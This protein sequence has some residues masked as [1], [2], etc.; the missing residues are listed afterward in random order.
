MAVSKVSDL[1][2]LFNEIFEDTLFVAREQNMMTNLVT[3]YSARGWM[4]RNIANYPSLT[5]E[6]VAEAVD[7]Q[8][9]TTFDKSLLATLTPGEIMTQVV[10]TDRRIETD[11]ED[12]RADAS[13]EMGNAVATKI[14]TDIV[15]D[16]GSLT[17][18]GPGAGNSATIAKVAVCISILRNRN[19]P[20]P[21]YVV[22]H[23]YHWHDVWVELGQPDQYYALLGDVANQ[24]LRDF[25]VGRWLNVMWFVNS[26]IAV[27]SSDDATSA[28]FNSQAL[29]FDSRKPP[30]MEPERDASLRAWE[31]NLSAGYAHGVRRSTHGLAY[32]ADAA[33]PT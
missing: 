24:A 32:I 16:F 17:D 18:K 26:N 23:P 28:V 11:P 13:T 21:I 10:L 15:G 7:Y 29:A 3:N 19:V 27:D 2:S 14:D 1:N 8:N 20:N 5:A 25:F 9:P 30:T 4:D 33:E 12:A 6:V 31:L 22:M